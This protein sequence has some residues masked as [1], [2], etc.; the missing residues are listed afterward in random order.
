MTKE[1]LLELWNIIEHE[2]SKRD[3]IESLEMY[4]IT[5]DDWDWLEVEIYKLANTLEK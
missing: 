4:E 1:K 3:L 5:I 2:F